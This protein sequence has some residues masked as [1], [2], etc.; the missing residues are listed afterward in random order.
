MA[1]PTPSFPR[2]TFG[3]R[4]GQFGMRVF[5]GFMLVQ[6]AMRASQFALRRPPPGAI[7]FV[8]DS[9]THG[10]LWDEW[11]PGTLVINR[12]IGGETSA[13]VLRR[14]DD[15][16][17]APAAVFLLIGTNDISHLLPLETI[18]ANIREIVARI[19][20]DAPAAPLYV[21][22]VM[23][24]GKVHVQHL[25]AL[26]QALRALVAAQ[27]GGVKYLDLW[28]ALATPESTLRAEFTGD[29][30]HLNG[31]GYQAWVE[32]LRPRVMEAEA[33]ATQTA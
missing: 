5:A 33:R 19:R 16:I 29:A 27:D 23:P 13:D 4:A 28:P 30:L 15:A 2:P 10:G 11:F 20:R 21:Q 6:Q 22:S 3:Q 1:T 24:R 9:I 18:V 31:A 7:V 8:G 26:N 32:V 12:G 17:N 25:T 14:I